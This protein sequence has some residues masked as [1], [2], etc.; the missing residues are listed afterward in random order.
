LPAFDTA[1]KARSQDQVPAPLAG[2]C[3]FGAT[4]R[5]S[6]IRENS[7]QIILVVGQVPPPVVGQSVMI[8]SFLKGDYKEVSLRH[9]AMEFSRS[10]AEIGA[11][12]VRKLW[13]LAK[14]LFDILRA[15]IVSGASILYYPPAGPN[16]N[17]V[18]RDLALLIPT[19]WLFR[20]TVFH[21]HA[22]GLSS[23]YPQLAWWMKPLFNWA[24]RFPDLA[25]FT[26]AGT[27]ACAAVLGAKRTAVVPCGVE[28]RGAEYLPRKES[29]RSAPPLIL[30]MGMLSEG[31]GLLVLLEACGSLLASGLSFKLM[32]AGAFESEDLRKR[33][34]D[35][36]KQRGLEDIVEFP[37]VLCGNKKS[38]AFAAA[39]IFCFPSHYFAESFGVVLVEAMSFC[40]P[41]VTT[42][43]RAI[44]EVVGSDGGALIVEPNDSAL[45]AESLSH[46]L[47]SP[48]AREKMGEI[49]RRRFLQRFTVQ[50]YRENMEHA[51]QLL[52]GPGEAGG[53][54]G[55]AGGTR[56]E[57]LTA[58]SRRGTSG[59]E[60]QGCK[61]PGHNAQNAVIQNEMETPWELPSLPDLPA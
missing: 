6:D 2:F 23:I 46:L 43:W 36:I 56:A 44:P 41:I 60:Q 25:I 17:A 12:G 32:C 42:R 10:T 27:S 38:D 15:R 19:R 13:I 53:L 55:R 26:T 57:Y 34:D 8:E 24:Y 52:E 5:F 29:Y 21:F 49:N 59:T 33:A 11:F 7:M 35:L 54:F 31:K 20:K 1:P 47:R 4:L 50:K 22:A 45:F 30:Y 58:H 14:T 37:G 28:D 3:G 61:V 51:L 9:V 16:L 39:S 48:E 18:M 40:L